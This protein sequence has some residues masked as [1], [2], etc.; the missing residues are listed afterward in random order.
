MVIGWF[1]SSFQLANIIVQSK[2]DVEKKKITMTKIKPIIIKISEPTIQEMSRAIKAIHTFDI[3][4]EGVK[5]ITNA[6]KKI[7]NFHFN[8]ASMV[9]PQQATNHQSKQNSSTSSH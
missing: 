5:S 4:P 1:A 9:P 7:T 3:S 2:L 8:G 6:F